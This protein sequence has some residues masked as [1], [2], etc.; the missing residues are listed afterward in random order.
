MRSASA[1]FLIANLAFLVNLP[2]LEDYDTISVSG[3]NFQPKFKSDRRA[4]RNRGLDD[5][6]DSLGAG[7]GLNRPALALTRARVIFRLRTEVQGVVAAV[8]HVGRGE[9]SAAATTLV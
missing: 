3:K 5:W 8:L 7:G 2:V 1:L 9:P 6:F 4:I